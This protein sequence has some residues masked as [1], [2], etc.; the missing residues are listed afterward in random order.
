MANELRWV[1]EGGSRAGVPAAVA[2]RRRTRERILAGAVVLLALALA[3]LAYAWWPQAPTPPRVARFEI[4][5]P[6]DLA[7]VQAP[8]VSP[9]GRYI[10]FSATGD[11]GTPRIWL[12]A[13]DD[14]QA[15]PLAGSE[16]TADR[17]FWSPDSRYLGFM[18]EG[19]LKKIP[20]GGGPP[21][22][23]CDAPTG[24]DGAWSPRGVILF[25]GRG[26]D[27]IR[28]VLAT[29]GVSQPFIEAKTGE[30]GYQV[31]WPSFLPDGQHFVYVELPTT[32][33]AS[34]GHSN[35]LMLASLD[36][37]ETPK[38]LADVDSLAQYVAP[39]Y[40]IFV[41]ENSLLAQPFDA[42]A[43]KVI[44]EPVP[45]AEKLGTSGVGLADFSASTDGTLVYR[46]GAAARLRLVLVDRTGK[47]VDQVGDPNVYYDPMLSPDGSQLAVDI[48]N[49]QAGGS[50]DIWLRDLKRGT[51]TRFTFDPADD[52]DAVWSP[53][54][55][56]I[57][58]HSSRGDGNG[59]YVKNASG[60][61]AVTEVF[62]SENDIYPYSWSRD[63]DWLLAFERTA[64]K[65][66]D[67]SAIGMSGPE[68]GKA[69]PLVS[70]NA[71]EFFPSFSPDGRWIAYVSDESGQDEVYV[72][73]FTGPE[74][75]WQV[76]TGGGTEAWWSPLG[77][78]IFYL[79][80]SQRMMAVSVDTKNG[81]SYGAPQILFQARLWANTTTR[82][83]WVPAPDGKH[84]LLLE[85]ENTARPMTLVQ[86][87]PQVLE[88]R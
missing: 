12:R 67:V 52:H 54:G 29:G 50:G 77:D 27:P 56:R 28:R 58:F 74:G 83:R 36:E 66:W 57:L 4:P 35:R 31:G 26:N 86:H 44:G 25:D 1:A 34:A 59:L 17:P 68:A 15:R 49:P 20:I 7:A 82:A 42:E 76:S 55:T 43:L 16:N 75:K 38:K 8:R 45:L 21:Q 41:R 33:G 80:Q 24:S 18:S 10:A 2:S 64:E 84:F 19:K 39:G 70:T 9:D 46:S 47:E 6:P 79:S 30:G 14:L 72:R 78:E 22:I 61:G 48:S 73:P 3:G 32:G 13:M 71:N 87:W 62:K 23:V 5:A 51:M 69:K 85:P 81:F 40:L 88:Q 53:D 11:D 65:G 63:G 37:K 60:L